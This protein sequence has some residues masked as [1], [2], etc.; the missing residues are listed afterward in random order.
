MGI[1]T[2]PLNCAPG[3][4]SGGLAVGPNGLNFAMIGS[5][6]GIPFGNDAPRG[7]VIMLRLVRFLHNAPNV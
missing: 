7:T 2:W 4:F 6:V 1:L 3:V 5:S